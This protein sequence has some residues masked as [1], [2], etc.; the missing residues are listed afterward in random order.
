MPSSEEYLLCL[1]IEI[2]NDGLYIRM[3]VAMQFLGLYLETTRRERR[4]VGGD[5]WCNFFAKD[6]LI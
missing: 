5:V 1:Y 2:D 6:I 3:T 4:M